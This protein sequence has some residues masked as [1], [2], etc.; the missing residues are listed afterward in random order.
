MTDPGARI[1]ARADRNGSVVEAGA[2]P[3]NMFLR[4]RTTP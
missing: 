3:Q 2:D 1:V 4:P